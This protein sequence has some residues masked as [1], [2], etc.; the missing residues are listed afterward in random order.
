LRRFEIS[1]VSNILR[2]KIEDIDFVYF[3]Q[4]LTATAGSMAF[5]GN[6][7]NKLGPYSQSVV[8]LEIPEST[9]FEFDS[10]S[11]KNVKIRR[12]GKWMYFLPIKP[13][14]VWLFSSPREHIVLPVRK[15]EEFLAEISS[16]FKVGLRKVSDVTTTR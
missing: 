10:E 13:A 11:H 7:I 2:G 5:G 16:I 12:I 15:L 9:H 8:A 6:A 1:Q 14:G 3:E 4:S